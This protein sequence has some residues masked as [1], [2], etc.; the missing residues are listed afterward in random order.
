VGGEFAIPLGVSP[1]GEKA[2]ARRQSAA[3]ANT[4]TLALGPQEAILLSFVQEHGRIK[5]TLRS[6]EDAEIESVK[7]ADWDTLFE[8]LYPKRRVVLE[9]EQPVV[10]I[11]RGLQRDVIPLSE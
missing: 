1:A 9:G 6:S 5:L 3:A 2:R 4:V 7:P 11:Y 8:Y 10:E